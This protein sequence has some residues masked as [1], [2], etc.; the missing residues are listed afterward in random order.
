M[1]KLAYMRFA[2]FLA[3][4]LIAILGFKVDLLLGRN[5][6]EIDSAQKESEQRVSVVS[7]LQ[8]RDLSDS[9]IADTARIEGKVPTEI[10][11]VSEGKVTEVIP[12]AEEIANEEVVNLVAKQ[13]EIE[14]QQANEETVAAEN[15]Q[16][17]VAQ[18]AAD[19]IAKEESRKQFQSNSQTQPVSFD[20]RGTND[21]K[22]GATE[23]RGTI[24]L[25][26]V[27]SEENPALSDLTFLDG[28][29]SKS[30]PALQSRRR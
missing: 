22:S 13:S 19:E 29:S 30:I 3:Y 11:T 15:Q 23:L 24:I 10:R 17:E 6:Q 7:V 4:T 5:V 21:R 9:R 27:D 12:A 14:Q 2:S 8:P 28:T 1:M 25:P 16:Q 20:R 26:D 18:Q